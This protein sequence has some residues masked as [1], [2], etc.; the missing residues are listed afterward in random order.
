MAQRRLYAVFTMD[1]EQLAEHSLDGGP[2]DWDLSKRAIAGFAEVLLARDFYATYFIVP[3]TSEQHARLF[4]DLQGEGFELGLHLHTVDQG[5]HDHLGGLT[6]EEQREALARASD[7]F[8]Q[9]LG[10][11]PHAFRGGNFSANDYTFPILTDLGF[12]YTS[13]S[14]PG[15]CLLTRRSVWVGALPYAHFAHPGNRLLEG[16]L[17]LVEVPISVHP[18]QFH[19]TAQAIPWEL[20]IEGQEWKHHADIVDANLD[21]QE[22]LSAPLLTCIVFTHNTWDYSDPKGEMTLR[23]R[24]LMDILEEKAAQRG[25]ELVKTTVGGV[26]NTLKEVMQR[27]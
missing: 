4:L 21:W 16:N 13:A 17:P 27:K 5:W 1:C 8:A 14:S 22:R 25:Y 18:T 20:R 23:L 12:T 9:A 15:R 26:H 2:R 7:R 6:P 19:D 24:R 11:A 10:Q 3:Q